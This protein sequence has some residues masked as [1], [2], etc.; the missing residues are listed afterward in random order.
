MSLSD[1][2]ERG[3]PDAERLQGFDAD[4]TV[5]SAASGRRGHTH[6]WKLVGNAVCVEMSAWV[7]HRLAD[8]EPYDHAL[9]DGEPRVDGSRWPGAAYSVGGIRR[10]VRVTEWPAHEHFVPLA[11]FLQFPVTP[12]SRRATAGFLERTGRSSLRFAD[13]F[14]EAVESHLERSIDRQLALAE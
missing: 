8:P 13:G 3:A 14:L 5:A 11:E 6:R 12:L 2:S 4:W 9:D 1:M 10:K 7:G